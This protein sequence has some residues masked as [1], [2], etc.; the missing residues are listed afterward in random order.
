MAEQSKAEERQG[1]GLGEE[2]PADVGRNLSKSIAYASDGQILKVRCSLDEGRA[3][4]P[5]SDMAISD[6]L[7][8]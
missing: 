6:E 5:C 7:E 8:G 2:D 4:G 3:L 1:H